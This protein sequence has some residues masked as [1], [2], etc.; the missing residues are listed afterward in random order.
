MRVVGQVDQR[1]VDLETFLCELQEDADRAAVL[2]MADAL[3]QIDP[4]RCRTHRQEPQMVFSG[5]SLFQ[6]NIEIGACCQE[7]AD[8]TTNAIRGAST[9]ALGPKGAG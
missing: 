5:S 4:P 2:A 8:A 9:R 7:L 6:L 3:Q 1:I